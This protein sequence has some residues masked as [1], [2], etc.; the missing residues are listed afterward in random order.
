LDFEL[1]NEESDSNES[2]ELDEEV[3]PHTI[4]IRRFGR[5]RRKE[6]RY[7]PLDFYSTYVLSISDDDPKSI[8]EVVDLGEGKH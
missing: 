6:E 2:T 3:E 4:V 8:R 5:V 7:S 1:K